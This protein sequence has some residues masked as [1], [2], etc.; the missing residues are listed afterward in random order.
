MTCW[1]AITW[2]RK[3]YLSSIVLSINSWVFFYT[4]SNVIN[5]FFSHWTT[6]L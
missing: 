5:L 6:W 3:S 4:I 2:S 1:S